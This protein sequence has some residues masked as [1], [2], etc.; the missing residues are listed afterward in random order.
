MRRRGWPTRESHEQQG[1]EGYVN[2]LEN[3][4]KVKREAETLMRSVRVQPGTPA[5]TSVQRCL[6]DTCS[7]RDKGCLRMNQKMK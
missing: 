4:P 2:F 1:D 3:Y 6:H 5:A 7:T